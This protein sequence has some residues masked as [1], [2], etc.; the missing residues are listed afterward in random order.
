MSEIPV[1]QGQPYL[2]S[3]TYSREPVVKLAYLRAIGESSESSCP[4]Y[5]YISRRRNGGSYLQ[6]PLH[7][8]HCWATFRSSF[9]MVVF[10]ILLFYNLG[11]LN[12]LFH[13]LL[14]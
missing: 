1:L 2:V 4:S 5:H 14:C 9:L 10:G 11:E 3:D 7:L 6:M 12:E 13:F 8:M